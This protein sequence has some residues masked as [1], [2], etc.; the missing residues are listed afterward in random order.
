MYTITMTASDPVIG[1]Y[2]LNMLEITVQRNR[3]IHLSNKECDLHLPVRPPLRPN[4]TKSS[5]QQ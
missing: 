3:T 5:G 1:I 2:I 4:K